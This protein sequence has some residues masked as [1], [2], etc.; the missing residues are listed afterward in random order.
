MTHDTRITRR[1]LSCQFRGALLLFVLGFGGQQTF[2]VTLYW[3]GD[4]NAV[5]NN[6]T[7]GAGLGGTGSGLWGGTTWYNGSADVAWSD[8]SDAVFWG[9][10]AGILSPTT[11]RIVNSLSFK[12]SGYVIQSSTVSLA[13][14]S[15]TVDSARAASISSVL[16]GT[17]GLVKSGDGALH[18]GG[19][20]T[21]SGGSTVNGGV[22]GIIA[23]ALG[24]LPASPA[25]DI[26]LN[27]GATLRYNADGMA[28]NANRQMLLGP[29]GG[30]INTNGFNGEFS[31]VITGS[32]LTKTGAGT[33]TLSNSNTYNGNT[34]ISAGA[35]CV[36]DVVGS[37][38]GSGY[39][40]VSAGATLG[41]TGTV[42][43][44]VLNSGTL[45]PGASIG[46]LH[47]GT[48]YF[49]GPS[50]KLEIE[51]ASLGSY[52][53]LIIDCKAVS[54]GTLAVS[55][56][57]GFVPEAGNSFEILTAR[58]PFGG[59]GIPFTTINLP[60]LSG[61]LAWSVNYGP[62]NVTLSVTNPGDFN[63][64]GTVDGA[65]YIVW[66]NGL[67]STYQQSDYGVWRSHFGQ[68][69]SAAAST[70]TVPE[71]TACLLLTVGVLLLPAAQ[72]CRLF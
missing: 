15:I 23:G 6:I 22:L 44:N 24:A 10:T 3:D 13:G 55:L 38:T 21:Y 72:R 32:S 2:A 50:G 60:A 51:I 46:T 49:Q 8:G 28:L 5:G 39:V 16:T 61:N 66:R 36:N 56:T 41:G 52:D 25:I 19:F 71:P 62:S 26:T 30:T 65:D 17:A 34:T 33:L 40:A 53:K 20:N 18:L 1:A 4:G 48:D 58:V 70:G 29:G 42:L 45:A 31:G 37:G 59:S 64:S 35:L 68:S 69:G 47:L 43:G 54:E 7:T 12:T 67:G 63:N 57:N 11:T 27:N 9:P 14:S